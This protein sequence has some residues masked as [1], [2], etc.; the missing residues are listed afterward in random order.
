[1]LNTSGGLKSTILIAKMFTVENKRFMNEKWANVP[2]SLV[3]N[4]SIRTNI[5]HSVH[6][7]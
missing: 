5:D 3:L 6:I 2:R 7:Q 4:H 1:M